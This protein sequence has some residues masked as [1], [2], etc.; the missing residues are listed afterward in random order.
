MKEGVRCSLEFGCVR[1][2]NSK[3]VGRV[4]GTIGVE[5]KVVVSGRVRLELGKEGDGNL[6][7]CNFCLLNLR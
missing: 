5:F 3:V 4:R 7:I 2:G 1:S 6:S